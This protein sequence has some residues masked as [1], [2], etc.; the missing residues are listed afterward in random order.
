[1]IKCGVYGENIFLNS[2]V[3]WL[4]A[5]LKKNLVAVPRSSLLGEEKIAQ[6][7]EASL[8]ELS[9]VYEESVRNLSNTLNHDSEGYDFTIIK[10]KLLAIIDDIMVFD[11]ID[12][13]ADY[14]T[15]LVTDVEIYLIVSG[16]YRQYVELFIHQLPRYFYIY[17]LGEWS[18]AEVK[19]Y[20]SLSKAELEPVQNFQIGPVRPVTGR[21]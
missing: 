6:H 18:F 13:C 19:K 21:S 9:S 16:Q 8:D 1:M 15:N 14:I 17:F 7:S 3:I 10:P 5:D 20:E 2:I 12:Q 11:D 4:D